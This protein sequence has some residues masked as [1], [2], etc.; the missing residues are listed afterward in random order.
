[1]LDDLTEAIGALLFF[2]ALFLIWFVFTH[3]A[4]IANFLFGN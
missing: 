1:M 4:K 2:G 3:H